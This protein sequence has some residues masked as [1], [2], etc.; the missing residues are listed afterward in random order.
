MHQFPSQQ[1]D[2]DTIR[3]AA[4]KRAK[5]ELEANANK[6]T[7][8]M[9]HGRM[10]SPEQ[11][12]IMRQAVNMEEPNRDAR[13]TTTRVIWSNPNDGH[14]VCD[15]RTFVDHMNSEG[16]AFSDNS[17][18]L[19]RDAY[20]PWSKNGPVQYEHNSSK[21]I[22]LY[23]KVFQ[24]MIEHSE[25]WSLFWTN[26]QNIIWCERSVGVI[27]TYATILRQKSEKEKALNVLGYPDTLVHCEKVLNLGGR[28]L[29]LFKKMAYSGADMF[30]GKVVEL[31]NTQQTLKGLTYRYFLI[32][33]NLLWQT[34]RHKKLNISELRFVCEYELE[35]CSPNDPPS[36]CAKVADV[37]LKELRVPRTKEAFSSLTNQQIKEAYI[38]SSKKHIPSDAYQSVKE[39]SSM[40]GSCGKFE[41]PEKKSCPR[42]SYKK[43]SACLTEHY[44]SRECQK[45]DWKNHKITCNE[46]KKI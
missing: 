32:K 42:E 14:V 33:H 6:E 46:N 12:D 44:C 45:K 21:M 24:D 37:L 40:C 31:I 36:K 16:S 20:Y 23:E 15:M 30:F 38:T 27:N 19:L 43:C 35:N 1:I 41:E 18:S 13:D 11:L 26:N 5:D 34:N 2:E 17:M 9:N 4:E 28:Q 29:V 22:I 39:W 3:K 7:V 8:R 10:A 25:T